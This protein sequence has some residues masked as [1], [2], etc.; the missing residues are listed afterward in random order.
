MQAFGAQ[1]FRCVDVC[2]FETA[3][4]F[5]CLDVFFCKNSC[6]HDDFN[7]GST[8]GNRYIAWEVNE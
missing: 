8:H 4:S 6:Y 7:V 3:T 1:L 5:C 2:I